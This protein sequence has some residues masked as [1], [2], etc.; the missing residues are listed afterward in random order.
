L[1]SK[2]EEYCKQINT[3]KSLNICLPKICTAAANALDANLDGSICYQT[4]EINQTYHL[5]VK[6]CYINKSGSY[7]RINLLSSTCPFNFADTQ[8]QLWQHVGV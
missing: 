8:S 7:S 6:T 4:A 5:A 1:T 3:T 2:A